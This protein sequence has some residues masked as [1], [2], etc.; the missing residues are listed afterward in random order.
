MTANPAHRQ[1]DAR[2][3]AAASS[4]KILGQAAAALSA[5][6]AK[7]SA[8]QQRLVIRY[9]A[10]LPGVMAKVLA[11]LDA[12]A[13]TQAIALTRRGPIEASQGAGVGELLS[14]GEG[15]RQL[16]DYAL[17]TG[18]DLNTWAGPTAGPV[19]IE[20]R[21]GVPRSTLHL[22]QTKG[23]VIR[24][25]DGVRKPVFPIEQFVESKPIAGIADVLAVIGEP[26]TTWMWLKE[27]H[28]L[29][30]DATPLARLQRG[31]LAEVMDAARTNFDQ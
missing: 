8:D 14:P 22:W 18:G 15:A 26:N 9:Q 11:E 19:E 10:R 29:L 20:R 5:T 6:A 17:A 25:V 3:H 12:P 13:K 2:A 28:P 16:H 23:L 21:L 27:P 1:Q 24:L 4:I 31:A 7:L 30:G